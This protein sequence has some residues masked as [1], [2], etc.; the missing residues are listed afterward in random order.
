MSET[1]NGEGTGD[2]VPAF[3]PADPAFQA[4]PF[5]AYR[6]LRDEFPLLRGPLGAFL[7]SRYE[8]CESLLR[9]RRMG[10]DFANSQFFEQVMGQAGDEAPPFLG[11]GLDDFDAKLFMLTDPPEHT[12]LRGLVS[13]AFT[14]AT[15]K[16]L[17]PSVTAVVDELLADLPDRFDLMERLAGPMPIR[18]LGDMLGIPA[19]DHARFTAWSTEIAGLLDLDVELPPE[20]AQARRKAVAECTGYFLELAGTRGSGDDLISQLVRARDEDSVLTTQEIAATCVLLVVA[21]QET[22]SNLV[23]NA[24]VVFSRQPDAFTHLAAHPEATDA[25]LDEI[26]RLEPPAHQ[27][28]RI[29]LEPVELHGTTIEPGNA[30]ILLVAS[31]NRDERAFP[32]P[33]T[34]DTGREGPAHLS[35]GRGV[36][37]CLGAPLANL[38]AKEVLRGLTERFSRLSMVEDPPV[39]KPGMGLRGPA[40]LPLVA[41]RRRA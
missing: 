30:V 39:Y 6:T 21:A 22:F 28:G 36:H 9:D 2:G 33:D 4:D 32:E 12:R 20:A 34:F 35:F 37:Y 40:A 10:K 16:K 29:A 27:V 31:A 5:P 24:A 15:I 17:G 1:R 19:E 23:G 26:M 13:Q 11:L 41:E 8:D 3:D 25:V 38:M 18:V 7:V 14:P